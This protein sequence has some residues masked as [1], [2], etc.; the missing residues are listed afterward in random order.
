MT[1]KITIKK[2]FD[3]H[4]HFRRGAM[5][6]AVAPF[7][8]RECWGALVMPNT[9]PHIFTPEDAESYK[10][11]IRAAVG[12]TFH[13]VMAGY[14]TPN[15]SSEDLKRGYLSGAWNAMKV[16]PPGATTHSHEGVAGKDLLKHP[17]LATM[18]EIGMPL[19]LHGEVN[20]DTKGEEID[21]YDREKRFLEEVVPTLLE[22]YPALKISL[23]HVTTRAIAE[24][25]MTN[26][27]EGRLVCTIT[28]QHLLFD[29]RMLHKDGFQPHLFCYPILKRKEDKEAI[30]ALAAAGKPFV[31]AGTDSAPHPTQSKEKAAGCAGGVFSAHAMVEMY[32][33]AFDDMGALKHLESFLS[34]N[35]PRFFSLEP[36]KE[37]ITLEKSAWTVDEMV[38]VDNGDKVRPFGFDEKAEN[39]FPFAW[40]IEK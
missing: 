31:S 25:M 5:L 12:D 36:S 2:P 27:K 11:E 30:R 8:A 6:K 18:E 17:G 16:Y 37:S 15:T 24:F 32:T 39:R 40:R 38:S 7:T 10:A 22:K 23:E 29:R 14:L 13:I 1:E 28:P 26:G 4:V 20:K 34:I 35:G 9:A 19:L 33:Q 21:I 3:A